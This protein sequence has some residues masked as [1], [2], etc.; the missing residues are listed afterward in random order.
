MRVKCNVGNGYS[1]TKFGVPSILY[2]GKVK[3]WQRIFAYQ[4]WSSILYEGKVKF[5]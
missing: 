5:W 2:E 1:L 4:I 3:F